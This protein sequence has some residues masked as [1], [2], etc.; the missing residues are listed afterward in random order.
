M[1]A[2]RSRTR[3]RIGGGGW[4]AWSCRR[5][6][7]LCVAIAGP[8]MGFEH[9]LGKLGFPGMDHRGTTGGS[10][11]RLMVGGEGRMNCLGM[12][13]DTICTYEMC[14]VREDILVKYA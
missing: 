13:L 14:N 11:W 3:L 12:L 10:F 7:R 6:R 9:H 5:R 4:R 2:W 8:W 1:L